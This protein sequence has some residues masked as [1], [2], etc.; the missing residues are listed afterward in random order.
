MTYFCP[1]CF[2]KINK[3]QNICPYCGTNIVI[4]ERDTDYKQKLIHALMHPISEYRMGA[5]ISLGNLATDDIAI[6]LVQCALRYPTDVV[7]AI[8]ILNA[9]AKIPKSEQKAVA[10]QMLKK[11][12]S[13]LI[14]RYIKSIS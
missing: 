7:Q 2:K 5:I 3:Q 9:L 4:W 13:A 10:L 1:Y 14:K 6:P 11:H 12:P 8:E